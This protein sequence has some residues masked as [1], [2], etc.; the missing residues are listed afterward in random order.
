MQSKALYLLAT[1]GCLKRI[2]AFQSAGIRQRRWLP[3]PT[4]SS[5][6]ILSISRGST[7]SAVSLSTS[8]SASASTSTMAADRDLFQ[9]SD[10]SNPPSVRNKAVQDNDADLLLQRRPFVIVEDQIVRDDIIRSLHQQQKQKQQ[11]Q[12]SSEGT[13]IADDDFSSYLFSSDNF[14]SKQFL[15]SFPSGAYTTSRTVKAQRVLRLKQ[16]L[17][18]MAESAQLMIGAQLQH[19]D[20]DKQTKKSIPKTQSSSSA[21]QGDNFLTDGIKISATDAVDGVAEASI[22]SLVKRSLA[23]GIASFEHLYPASTDMEKRITTLLFWEP[24][25]TSPHDDTQ[26]EQRKDQQVH[27]RLRVLSYVEL[28]PSPPTGRIIA[29]LCRTQRAN[30]LAKDSRWVNDR[31]ALERRKLPTDPPVHEVLLTSEVRTDADDVPGG[32]GGGRI[33]V[34]EGLSSNF[35]AIAEDGVVYTASAEEGVL[36][37]TLRAIV[38][39][40]CKENGIK[41]KEE[42]PLLPDSFEEGDEGEGDSNSG[43][44]KRWVGAFVSS[45][46]RLA[47]PL[48]DLI[49]PSLTSV[50]AGDNTVDIIKFSYTGMDGHDNDNSDSGGNGSGDNTNVAESLGLVVGKV[51]GGNGMEEDGDD[52][53]KVSYKVGKCITVDDSKGIM[54]IIMDGVHSTVLGESERPW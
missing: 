11:Q 40:V 43:G 52:F 5:V 29:Q 7:T 30:A 15:T 22:T 25:D 9:F 37:G 38:I 33:G 42:A 14:T 8:A 51:Q 48:T 23:S 2:I 20:D 34:L 53:G 41:V 39:Q 26:T 19:D 49:V 21:W 46:T 1:S 24:Y 10:P 28:L 6:F 36:L 12:S 31:K 47:L 50:D 4:I 16:H 3:S 35:Y 13:N 32:C 54:K 17:S 44:G 27:L 45:T 18:R